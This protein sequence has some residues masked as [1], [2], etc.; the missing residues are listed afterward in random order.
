MASKKI[1][2][3]QEKFI[4]SFSMDPMA[5]IRPCELCRGKKG[6]DSRLIFQSDVAGG[7]TVNKQ[8]GLGKR[9]AGDF[10]VH[11]TVR[12]VD[13]FQID[14]PCKPT[15]RSLKIL[16]EEL[17]RDGAGYLRRKCLLNFGAGMALRGIKP[18][19]SIEN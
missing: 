14:L 4:R 1:Q 13:R 15:V 7:K 6:P 2:H 16:H 17:S 9:S 3:D 8:S 10:P 18:D 11:F 5:H 12:T 19:Q